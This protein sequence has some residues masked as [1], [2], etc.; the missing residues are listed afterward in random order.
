MSSAD[1]QLYRG[2]KVVKRGLVGK[3]HSP[4]HE[5]TN[6]SEQRG[7]GG[8]L[9]SRSFRGSFRGLEDQYWNPRRYILAIVLCLSIFALTGS[10][11]FAYSMSRNPLVGH[12]TRFYVS[13]PSHPTLQ[14]HPLQNSQ[15]TWERSASEGI[16]EPPGARSSFGVEKSL[17]GDA[18]VNSRD[19]VSAARGCNEKAAILKVYMY[20]L[21]PEFHYG[22]LVQSP[23]PKG[24][25][26]PR[27][28]SEIPG[29]L[30]GLYQQH[31]PEYWLTSDLLTS[32]MAD[33][34]SM[35]TAYRVDDR[36]SADVIFVPFFASLSYNKYTRP[37]QKLALGVDKNV[38]LQEK[39]MDFLRRQPAWLSSGGHDHVIVIHHPNS[40]HAIRDQLRNAIFVVAD[41]GRYDPEV[42]NIGKDVVAPYKHVVQ[43]FPDDA[44]SFESRKTLLY[45]QGAIIR[46]EGGIIRQQLYELIKDEAGVHFEAGNTSSGAIRSATIGMQG[47]KF[48]LNLAGDTPSSNRLFD[49][50]ASHC[51]PVIISDD[52]EVP[53]EDELNYTKFCF[54]VKSSDAL[55][56]NFLINL[57]RGVSREEWTKMWR[58]LQ[59]VDHHFKYQHPTKPD[60]AVHMTWKAIARKASKVRLLLNKQRRFKMSRLQLKDS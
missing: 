43:A 55:K 3:D 23:F 14:R 58:K 60:D 41:F 29:Y 57:L 39:L 38:E 15:A 59:E 26:W 6:E 1:E 35:C 24:Q 32:N 4:N 7:R 56:K 10:F 49:S 47:S 52:V 36:R 28:V 53:F 40:M 22:M 12:E 20:D 46:K 48:C 5:T 8:L 30:G 17:T 25:I 51:V 27:N 31:S 2:D 9:F 18:G 37:E 19:D 44:T 50:I 21:P 54:F 45:F 11:M 16:M 33:R 13:D 42:A 34:E